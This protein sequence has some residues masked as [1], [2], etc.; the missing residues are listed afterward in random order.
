M[1]LL[2]LIHPTV[3]NGMSLPRALNLLRAKQIPHPD[4]VGDG[5]GGVLAQPDELPPAPAQRMS[6]ATADYIDRE[7]A[8]AMAQ[9]KQ[10]EYELNLRMRARGIQDGR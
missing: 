8:A 7:H 1:G 10:D 3:A 4:N 6:K 5:L 2:D 9:A